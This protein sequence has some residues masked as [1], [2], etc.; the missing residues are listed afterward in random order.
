MLIW[1]LLSYVM[2]G[3]IIFQLSHLP[4][5][6][7]V[8]CHGCVTVRVGHHACSLLLIQSQLMYIGTLMWAVLLYALFSLAMVFGVTCHAALWSCI[9]RSNPFGV[10]VVVKVRV[11]LRAE[12][13]A[14]YGTHAH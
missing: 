1:A 13:H 2:I 7:A 5:G 8:L 11:R 14:A 10:L 9:L 4:P 3:W 12:S 6:S